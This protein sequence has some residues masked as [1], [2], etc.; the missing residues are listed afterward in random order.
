M[1]SVGGATKLFTVFIQ[2]GQQKLISNVTQLLKADTR[3]G[4]GMVAKDHKEA[5]MVVDGELCDGE[6][7]AVTGPA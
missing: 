1:P 2:L 6:M 5:V 4:T 3:S 7:Q